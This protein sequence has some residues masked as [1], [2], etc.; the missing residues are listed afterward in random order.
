MYRDELG[1][2][3]P[4]VVLALRD[5]VSRSCVD[6][7]WTISSKSAEAGL[8]GTYC[9][10]GGPT[11]AGSSA[12]MENA[13]YVFVVGVLEA[14]LLVAVVLADCVGSATVMRLMF[15][16]PST[17]LTPLS[18]RYSS[19]AGVLSQSLMCLREFGPMGL[20]SRGGRLC[21]G[22]GMLSVVV[23]LVGPFVPFILGICGSLLTCTVFKSGSLIPLMC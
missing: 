21:W 8:F 18:R 9:R 15:N 22:I 14:E 2:V 20:L 3:P 13:C 1:V 10:A 23:V 16:L 4:D 6:D 7:F 11:E 19:F 5:A 12:F 17:L